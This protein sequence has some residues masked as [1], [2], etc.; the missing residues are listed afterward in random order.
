LWLHG[1]AASNRRPQ[2]VNLLPES[3]DFRDQTLLL[4]LDGF[5]ALGLADVLAD[6]LHV[7]RILLDR[8]ELDFLDRSAD[9]VRVIVVDPAATA[10]E[11]TGLSD[12]GPNPENS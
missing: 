1:Y 12:A 5:R 9:V 7:V 10:E 11:A 6:D 4:G 2:G 3:L 8:Q